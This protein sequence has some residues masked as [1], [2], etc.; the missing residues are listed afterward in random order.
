[1]PSFSPSGGEGV[2]RTG[3]GDPHRFTVP[4]P[5]QMLKDALR[6]PER[7]FASLSP[8]HLFTVRRELDHSADF[9]SAVSPNCIRQGVA[10]VP[11]D[12]VPQRLAECNSAIQQSATLRYDEPVNRYPPEGVQWTGDA[13]EPWQ[14]PE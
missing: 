6:E 7:P 1:I 3:E 4:M 10:S 2:R 13:Q 8:T 11:R 14:D 12:G 9:Q 5:A